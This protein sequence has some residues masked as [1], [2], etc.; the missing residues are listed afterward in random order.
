MDLLFTSRLTSIVLTVL[1][2]PIGIICGRAHARGRRWG[3]PVFKA[4]IALLLVWA[5]GILIL[6]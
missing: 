3:R 6:S 1:S 2:C 4:W 5:A